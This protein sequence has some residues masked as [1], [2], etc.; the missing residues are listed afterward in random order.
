[1]NEQGPKRRRQR[2][3]ASRR[4]VVS[5]HAAVGRFVISLLV[6]AIT[7]VFFTPGNVV[8]WV[9]AVVGWDAFA[10]TLVTLVWSVILR[11]DSAE[12]KR[13]AGS[14][15]PG[16]HFVFGVALFSSI[17]SFFAAA[18]VLR[19]V[20]GFDGHAKTTW[21]MLTLAAIVLA[22]VLAHT[23]YTL[24]YAHLYYG[25]SHQHGLQFPGDEP[26][27]DIDF[28]YFAFT[29]GMCF[30]V[31]DVVVTATHCRRAVLL[32]AVLSFVFNTAIL[33]LALNLVFS[34]MS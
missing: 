29:V 16:R 8:W 4:W 20:R 33:A 3:P 28:A 9:R 22:W 19:Y 21:T 26:P 17:V 34:T 18:F 23:V 10:L 32:H 15:D 1:M 27:A 12:T 7:F 11:A 30:Q 25:H 14:D 24:R 2:A 6:G 31:S 13:R 5:P